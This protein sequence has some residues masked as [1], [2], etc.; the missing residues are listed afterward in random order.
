M[1]L[2]MGTICYQNK[3]KKVS[4][5]KVITKM[6][7]IVRGLTN[8]ILIKMVSTNLVTIVKDMIKKDKIKMGLMI[9]VLMKTILIKWVLTVKFSYLISKILGLQTLLCY[10]IHL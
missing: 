6:V 5:I 7:R 1:K 8:Q 9:E 10:Y 4:T 2:E 3:M